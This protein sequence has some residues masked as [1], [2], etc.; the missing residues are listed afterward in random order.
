MEN[1]SKALIM[2]GG[3]LISLIVIGALLLMYDSLTS[4]QKVGQQN[5]EEA[6]VVE[7]NNQYE[8]FNRNNVRGSDLYSL[9]NRV[10][11][12][13]RRKSTEGRGKDEGQYLAY[14]PMTITFDLDGKLNDF[15]VSTTSSRD[16]YPHLITRDGYV[17]SS[18]KNEF[19]DSIANKVKI[20][21]S[22]YGADSLTNLTIALTKIFIA[23]SIAN[24]DEE[25]RNEAIRNFNSASKKVT[26]SSWDE[27]KEGSTIRQAVYQYYEYVQ[28]KRARFNCEKNKYSN[29]NVKYNQKTGRIIE[30]NFKFTGKFE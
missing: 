23:D 21:E 11:D 17:Q 9:L 22:T 14:E 25:K 4:Y 7:F 8:T 27:I 26:I 6:Q 29:T 3:I 1:A 18:T 13:N 12:Y 2:A 16:T 10:V 5:T 20:L 30:M 24:N 15:Y 28:F 19:E